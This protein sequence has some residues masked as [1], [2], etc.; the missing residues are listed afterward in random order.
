MTCCQKAEGT[1]T[2]SLVFHSGPSQHLL[3]PKSV[4]VEIESLLQEGVEIYFNIF[5]DWA[6]CNLFQYIG[7]MFCN[8]SGGIKPEACPIHFVGD[9]IDLVSMKMNIY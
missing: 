8:I 6:F 9:G 3:K 7:C 2:K 1:T 5:G 4:F